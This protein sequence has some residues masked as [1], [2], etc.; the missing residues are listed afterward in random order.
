MKNASLSHQRCSLFV[1]GVYWSYDLS[2]FIFL[3]EFG[4]MIIDSLKQHFC[5]HKKVCKRVIKSFN[6][7]YTECQFFDVLDKCL[8]LKTKITV[9]VFSMQCIRQMLIK[10]HDRPVL[11]NYTA[12]Y[13]KLVARMNRI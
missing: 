13:N 3:L 5:F 9:I 12:M 2:K 6:F 4:S 1:T 11:L 7:A 8:W 10:A